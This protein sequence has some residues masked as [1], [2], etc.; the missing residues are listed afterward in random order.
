MGLGPAVS[1][2]TAP[3]GPRLALMSYCPHLGTGD[4]PLNVVCTGPHKL[5]S[6][7]WAWG[8]H[9]TRHLDLERSRGHPPDHRA[10]GKCVSFPSPP[11][12]SWTKTVNGTGCATEHL[13]KGIR[14]GF[15]L[16]ATFKLRQE[17]GGVSQAKVWQGAW[18]RVC[19]EGEEREGRA[20]QTSCCWEQ[21]WVVR[22]A[23]HRHVPVGAG[24]SPGL[25]DVGG[26]RQGVQNHTFCSD[27]C[28]V[29][30]LFVLPG[31][32]TWAQGN[33]SCSDFLCLLRNTTI[34]KKNAELAGVSQFL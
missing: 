21:S 31:G 3:G 18:Q 7:F 30:S 29:P 22:A 16:E 5:R 20:G 4:R 27:S 8:R 2:D 32:Q 24:R 12:P 33:G 1:K 13:A 23:G 34:S 14:E 25:T 28:H 19:K 9:T 26:G 11:H 17:G 10:P 6:G 15:L